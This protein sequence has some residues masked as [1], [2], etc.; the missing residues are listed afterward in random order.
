MFTGVI[1]N[2]GEVK[3]SYK[4]SGSLFLAIKKPKSWKIKAGESLSVD[5]TCLT[6]K[7]MRNN[8]L[9]TE[10]MP[11]TLKRTTFGRKVPKR[12]NLERPLTLNSLLGGH[13]VLGH[14]DVVGKISDIKRQSSSKV[15]SV[16]FPKKYS[17]LVTEKGSIAVDGV[18]LAVVGVSP[19]RFSVSLTD[20]TLRNTTLGEKKAG[21]LVNIEFD[22]LAKYI[23]NKNMVK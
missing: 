11:E 23:V 2:I 15:Y 21:D 17:R 18:S 10:L 13:L 16:S 12:V 19:G 14:I 1:R 20:Y 5:G 22:I 3:K 9:V 4:K 6:V 7:E 8:L